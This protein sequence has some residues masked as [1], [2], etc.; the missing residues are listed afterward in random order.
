M[1]SGWPC[2]YRAGIGMENGQTRA[3]FRHARATFAPRRKLLPAQNSDAGFRCYSIRPPHFEMAIFAR[4]A[5]AASEA[6]RTKPRLVELPGP[7]R[8][9]DRHRTGSQSV[10]TGETAVAKTPRRRGQ[11]QLTR[12]WRRVRTRIRRCAGFEQP[13]S[14]QTVSAPHSPRGVQDKKVTSGIIDLRLTAKSHPGKSMSRRY[15][16]LRQ[17]AASR[18]GA[19]TGR[20]AVLTRVGR[21]CARALTSAGGGGAEHSCPSRKGQAAR[22]SSQSHC[23]KRMALAARTLP[24]G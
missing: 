8:L 9:L 6:E 12:G 10:P 22:A 16:G 11:R 24:D 1:P 4:H 2:L 23:P 14:N 17:P 13:A 15:P 20:G 3:G 5:L 19:A 7:W 18:A 21:G